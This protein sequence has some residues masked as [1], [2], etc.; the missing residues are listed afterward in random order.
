M[1][2]VK[3]CSSYNREARMCEGVRDESERLGVFV[4][5]LFFGDGRRGFEFAGLLWVDFRFVL[6]FGDEGNL[7]FC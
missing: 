1:S 3:R 7:G 2:R 5:S 4:S 6:G